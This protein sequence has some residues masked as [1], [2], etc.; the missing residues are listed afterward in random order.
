MVAI[1]VAAL[2]AIGSVFVYRTSRKVRVAGDAVPP[3]S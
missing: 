3:K 2:I 1:G